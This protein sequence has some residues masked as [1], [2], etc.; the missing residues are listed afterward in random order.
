VE[1]EGRTRKRRRLTTRGAAPSPEPATRRFPWAIAAAVIAATGTVVAAIGGLYFNAQ[2]VRQATDQARLT[3]QAQASERFSRSVEQLGADSEPVRTGAIHAFGTL[4]RDSPQDRPAI[5]DIL[6]S[7]IRLQAEGGRL[8]RGPAN[9]APLDVRAAVAVLDAQPRPRKLVGQNG[10]VTTWPSMLLASIE[11]RG[12]SFEDAALRDADF[13]YA[14]F[15]GVDFLNADLSGS[16]LGH[17]EWWRS[18]LVGTDLDETNLE[19]ATL[20]RQDLV[21]ASLRNAKMHCANLA[22]AYL[23][24][25]R[26]SGADLREVD[27]TEALMSEADLSGANLTGAVMRDADLSGADLTGTVLT[28]VDLRGANLENVKDSSTTV[29]PSARGPRPNCG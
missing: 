15:R 6:S 20:Y 26:M 19:F 9:S 5:V 27:L 29:W 8:G 22:R 23:A 14:R 28:G 21:S 17:T 10:A 1:D 3:E 7:Y 11:L 13:Q 4:M 24:G 18:I 2:S 25:A 12:V 16:D